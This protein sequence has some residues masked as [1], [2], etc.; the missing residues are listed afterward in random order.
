[1]PDLT[2]KRNDTRPTIVINLKEGNPASPTAINLT[3]AVS[4]K[5]IMK[6]GATTITRPATV[7]NPSGGQ[8]TVTFLAADTQT[9]GD[10][11]AEVEITWDASGNKETVPN[12]GYLA[13]RI[14]DDLG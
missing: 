1:V 14:I 2:L 13:I 6:M 8:I 9:S 10:Y 11:Q 4:V 12:D 7:T 3:T 5:L